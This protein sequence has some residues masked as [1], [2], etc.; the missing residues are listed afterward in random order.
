MPEGDTLYRT[1]R[2]LDRALV[3]R[4]VTAFRSAYAPLVAF[5]DNAPL[6]GRTVERAASR[7]KWLFLYFSGDAILVTHMLMRGSWHIYRPGEPWQLPAREMRIAIETAEI[8]AIAFNVPVA[9]MHTASSLARRAGIPP[10]AADVLGPEF[11]PISAAVRIVAHR[12]EEIG[13]VLLHQHVLAGVG[14]VFKSET[15][16]VAGVSPFARVSTL[17]AETIAHIVA[18][19]QRLLRANIL[20]DSCGQIV[21]YPSRMRRT[22]RRTQPGASLWVYGRTGEPCR[23]CGT[24]I[25][26]APQGPQV[27]TTYWCPQCQKTENRD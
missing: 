27:R 20:E 22:T 19:A 23:H 10:A 25:R 5:D 1:A 9:E 12:D 21:T 6:A 16:F 18:T 26:S 11:D 17:S 8:D 4:A 24:P 2:A 13:D 14:N 7:G 15:C 3:G